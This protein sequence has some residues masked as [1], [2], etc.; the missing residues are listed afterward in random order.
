MTKSS[1]YFFNNLVIK[2]PREIDIPITID[3]KI[4]VIETILNV[5]YNACKVSF[6][7][8]GHLPSIIKLKSRD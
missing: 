1:L 7:N 4:I 5:E 6:D 2:L 3:V 8:I